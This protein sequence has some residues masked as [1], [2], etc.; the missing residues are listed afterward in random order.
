MEEILPKTW[1]DGNQDG[2]NGVVASTFL[3]CNLA[4]HNTNS[5]TKSR[6]AS[7]EYFTKD[8]V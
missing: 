1:R 2:I 3:A 6:W 7:M 8:G 4:A 5:I